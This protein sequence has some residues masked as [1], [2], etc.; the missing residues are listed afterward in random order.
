MPTRSVHGVVRE[1]RVKPFNEEPAIGL[2]E[3]YAS[4]Q[5]IV[6]KNC[7]NEYTFMVQHITDGVDEKAVEMLWDHFTGKCID[8]ETN[9]NR[10]SSWRYTHAILEYVPDVLDLVPEPEIDGR[11]WLLF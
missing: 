2:I 1:Y 7:L 5:T 8:S 10:P 6:C 4:P 3:A 9:T 11:Q